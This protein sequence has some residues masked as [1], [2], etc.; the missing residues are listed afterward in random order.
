MALQ[1]DLWTRWLR[2]GATIFPTI[3]ATTLSRVEAMCSVS[4][5]VAV[6]PSTEAIMNT[7]ILKVVEEAVLYRRGSLLGGLR[8]D[9]GLPL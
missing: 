2:G 4:S 5:V 3:V 7:A 9:R 1:K 6:Q 8:V